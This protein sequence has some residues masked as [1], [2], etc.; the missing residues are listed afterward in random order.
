[1]FQKLKKTKSAFDIFKDILIPHAKKEEIDRLYEKY[2]Y[3][4]KN[5]PQSA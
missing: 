3:T 5:L 1:M 4:D 2:D